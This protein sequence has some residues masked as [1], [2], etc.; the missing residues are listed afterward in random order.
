[1]ASSIQKVTQAAYRIFS[2]GNLGGLA[3]LTR[4]VSKITAKELNFNLEAEKVRVRLG[5]P[6]P[7]AYVHLFEDD[8]LSIGIFVLKQ[9][10]N[11][12]LHDHPHMH[13]ICK[14]IYGTVTVRSFSACDVSSGVNEQPGNDLFPAKLCDVMRLSAEEEK[15]C[16]LSPNDGNIHEII[17]ENGSAAFLDILAPPYDHETGTRICQYY[18]EFEVQGQI[19][20]LQK[21]SPP[22][23]FWCDEIE[24]SGPEIKIG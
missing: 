19:H 7:A 11:I 22:T 15:S 1:M 5:Q 18:S 23:N 6:A 17:A 3:E 4:Q 2:T 21:I 20:W 13:G 16:I 9:G 10:T 14:V 8:I 12:P 24:Y